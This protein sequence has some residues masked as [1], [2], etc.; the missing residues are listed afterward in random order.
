[1]PA[2][3]HGLKKAKAGGDVELRVENKST[4][5]HVVA[6]FGGSSTIYGECAVMVSVCSGK[7]RG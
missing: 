5:A 2:G 7:E 1:V 3:L 4:F 6:F